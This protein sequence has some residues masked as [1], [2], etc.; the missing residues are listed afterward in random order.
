MAVGSQGEHEL[1]TQTQTHTQNKSCVYKFTKVPEK[2]QLNNI[3]KKK[4]F[5][6]KPDILRNPR[7]IEG[8]LI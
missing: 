1:L 4:Q 2:S 7:R 8:V 3:R 6:L 5:A